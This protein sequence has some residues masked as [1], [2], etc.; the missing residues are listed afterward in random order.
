MD[1]A[2]HSNQTPAQ[3]RL[4]VPVTATRYLLLLLLLLLI[5]I[6]IIQSLLQNGTL[7]DRG[8]CPEPSFICCPGSIHCASSE[9]DCPSL[10][11]Y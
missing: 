6:I 7:C 5:I 9:E 11:K 2:A 3:S 8:C 1:P 4:S 10:E